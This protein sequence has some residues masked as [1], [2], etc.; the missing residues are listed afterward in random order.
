MEAVVF[1]ILE[2]SRSGQR[3]KVLL[4]KHMADEAARWN[5]YVALEPVP[6]G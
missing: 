2:F 3:L 4:P 6:A 5:G 1:V